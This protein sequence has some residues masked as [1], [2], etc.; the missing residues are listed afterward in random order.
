MPRRFIAV[1]LLFLFAGLAGT[2]IAQTQATP[3]LPAVTS[4]CKNDLPSPAAQPP[5]GS[6]PVVLFVELCFE[7]GAIAR[8]PG[9]TYARH[10]RLVPTVSLP[11]RGRWTPF[12][13]AV[14]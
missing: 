13:A 7:K 2:V 6:P 3:A 10:I 4:D 12:T 1:S 5:P 9:E 11:S 8:L 14:E